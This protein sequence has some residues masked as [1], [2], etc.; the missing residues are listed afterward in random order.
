MVMSPSEQNDRKLK[1]QIAE[2]SVDYANIIERIRD[3]VSE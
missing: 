1:E 2:I 3:L